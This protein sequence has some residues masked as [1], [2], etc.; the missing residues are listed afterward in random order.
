MLPYSAGIKPVGVQTAR[1]WVCC[2]CGAKMIYTVAAS[3]PDYVCL[4]GDNRW[5]PRERRIFQRSY[6]R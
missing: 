4:C 2:R 6:G 5:L 3:R 1:M